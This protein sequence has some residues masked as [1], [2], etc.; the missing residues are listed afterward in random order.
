MLGSLT[1]VPAL[2]R[3]ELLASPVAAAVAGLPREQVLVAEID[4]ALADTAAFCEHYGVTE[5]QSANCVVVA[6]RRGDV[7][8]LAACVVLATTRCDVNGVVRKRLEARKASFAP[9]DVATEATGM[10][11]GGITPVG[12]PVDWPML[13][14]DAAV[15][16]QPWVVVGSGVRHSKLVLPGSMLAQLPGA[17]VVQ[18][19]AR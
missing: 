2:D 16:Q 10:A 18:G 12:L 13:L 4:A 5:E 1:T 11:Y 8:T 14:V 17:E 3:P 19:L 7:T 9:M 6:G 15:V